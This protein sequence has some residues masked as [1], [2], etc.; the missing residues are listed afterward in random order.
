VSGRMPPAE[1]VSRM[2]ASAALMG[3]YDSPSG[4]CSIPAARARRGTS[5]RRSGT[6]RP[7]YHVGEALQLAGGGASPLSQERIPATSR[8]AGKLRPEH[9]AR[10]LAI[11]PDDLAL[12]VGQPQLKMEAVQKEVIERVRETLRTKAFSFRTLVADPPTRRPRG[13]GGDLQQFRPADRDLAS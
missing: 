3:Q 2:S 4:C 12:D 10:G 6:R 13:D 9:A 5:W 1:F 7:Q 11:L 8:V